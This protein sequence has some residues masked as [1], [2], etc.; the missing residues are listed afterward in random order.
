[1]RGMHL[2][3]ME[4]NKMAEKAFSELTFECDKDS[5]RVTFAR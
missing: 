4:T 3:T 2:A 1:M 5:S